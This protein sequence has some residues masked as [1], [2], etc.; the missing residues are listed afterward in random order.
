VRCVAVIA[1]FNEER[2]I[3]ACLEHLVAQGVEAFL[4]DNE[5]SDC[6]VAIAERFLGRGLLGIE[7]L[8]RG[9]RF[10][11]RA[12]LRRKERLADE[13]DADWLIHQDA[14][15]FRISR[16]RRTLADELAAADRQGFNAVNFLEFTFVPTRESPDH[17]H[18]RFRETMRWYYP[19]AP[20]FPHR[21]NAWKRQAEP[22]ELAWSGGHRVRFPGLRM[23][24]ESL[25]M[26]HYLC[27]SRSHF[28]R[29][30]RRRRYDREELAAGWHRWRVAKSSERARFPSAGRLRTY[31][32]DQ[33][34]DSSNPQALHL[35][36]AHY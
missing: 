27:L 31:V 26:R 21:L 9:A 3:G 5:S 14:D 16:R 11:L 18:A 15:E 4:I 19:F 2:L 33:A 22:V 28:E 8:P 34:L 36:G 23:A 10:S 25:A 35:L 30:Y 29:K 6:T 13:L 20:D 1:A 12:Q 17:D 32:S 7:T 24:P